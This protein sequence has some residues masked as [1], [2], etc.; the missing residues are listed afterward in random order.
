MPENNQSKPTEN[1]VQE[2]QDNSNK[3]ITPIPSKPRPELT[4]I[5][6]E[7]VRPD[8]IEKKKS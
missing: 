1:P 5:Q 3:P 6:T 2:P 4:D 8:D 7:G